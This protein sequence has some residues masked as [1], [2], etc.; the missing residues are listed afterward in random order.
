MTDIPVLYYFNG[1]GRSEIIRMVLC[2]GNIKYTEV[3]FTERQQF[4]QL[5][6]DGELLFNAV[7]MLKVDGMNL[8]QTNAILNYIA[9][10]SGLNGKD[11]KEKA[12]IDM[13]FEGSR[14]VYMGFLPMLFRGTEEEITKN[15]EPKID[16]YLPIYEKA[17]EK[18]GS[19]FLVGTN[20]TLADLGLM[21]LLLAIVDFY[22]DQKL[23]AYTQITKYMKMISSLEQVKHYIQNVRKPKNDENYVNTVKRVL[24]PHL[25]NK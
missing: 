15:E 2:A 9:T 3:D 16:K 22:G 7:P 13:Y 5:I 14:D 6:D 20:L 11:A 12:M 18:N 25:T 4:V 23:K 1:R 8:V 24:Y 17:L 21:E 10:K 19:G